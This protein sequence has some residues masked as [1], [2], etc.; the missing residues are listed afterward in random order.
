MINKNVTIGLMQRAVPIA[1]ETELALNMLDCYTIVIDSTPKFPIV[2]SSSRIKVFHIP[3]DEGFFGIAMM[4][5][6]FKEFLKT[7]S[8][9]LF[10]I[11]GDLVPTPENI[12][13]AEKCSI[14]TK[15]FYAE[16]DSNNPLAYNRR[17]GLA[18]ILLREEVQKLYSWMSE[19]PIMTFRKYVGYWD[20]FL[21]YAVSSESSGYMEG[22]TAGPGWIK[23]KHMT[24]DDSTRLIKIQRKDMK[25]YRLRMAETIALAIECYKANK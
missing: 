17:E 19:K 23:V 2:K 20:T 13:E 16:S 8:T 12:I 14:N 9:R 15:I 18:G 3:D 6:L 4:I 24:H 22:S 10:L 7:N 21:W 25:V 11:E 5:P 1:K